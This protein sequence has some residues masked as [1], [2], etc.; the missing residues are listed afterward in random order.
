MWGVDSG[1]LYEIDKTSGTA[2]NPRTLD[3][4]SDYQAVALAVPPFFPP[5]VEGTVFEDASGNAVPAGEFVGDF[6]NPGFAGATVRMYNDDGS[7]PGEPDA[8]DSLYASKATGPTGHYY[9]SSVPAGV[10]WLTVDSAALTPSAGGSGWPEQTYAPAEA[11]TFNGSYSYSATAGP[12]YGGMRPTVADDA[13]LLPSSEHVVRVD[14][15]PG[16]EIEQVDVGLSF[17]VVTNLEGGDGT[18][19]QGSLAQFIDNANTVT[20]PNAMRFV[21]AVPTNDI[22]GSDSWWRLDVTAALPQI[23][24]ADT[25][26]DG[27]AFDSADGTTVLDTNTAQIGGGQT[28]GVDAATSTARLDPELAIRNDRSTP[29]GNGLDVQGDGTVLTDFAIYGFGIGGLDADLR[30]GDNGGGPIVDAVT[31]DRV[32]V[33]TDPSRNTNPGPDVT[34][35]VGVLVAKSTNGVFRDS[36]VRSIGNYGMRLGL[37][38]TDWQILGS[39]FSGND[40]GFLLTSSGASVAGTLFASNTN[41]G[42][43]IS[44]DGQGTIDNN[45][46]EFNAGYGLALFSTA[47]GNTV[48]ENIISNNG[49]GIAVLNPANQNRLSQNTFGGNDTNGI[50]LGAGA[51]D[52]ITLNSGVPP[53]CGYSAG[54][55][56]NDGID[57]PVILS[58]VFDAGSTTINGTGCA[59]AEVEIYRAVADGD[60]SDT[61]G[62]TDFGEGVEYLGTVMADGV[63]GSFALVTGLLVQGDY[64]S[65]TSTDA[66]GNTS[67]FGANTEVVPSNTAPILDAVGAQSGDEGTLITFTATGSDSDL[68][69]DTLTFTLEDGAGSV[70]AGAS[71]TG[72]GVFTFTPSE[73]QGPGVFS[74]DVVVTDDGTPNLTDR[75]TITVTVNEVNIAPVL[76]AVGAQSGDEGTLV[77]FTATAS[78][79]DVPAN[80]LTFTL[81]DGAGS[82]PVGAVITG[83]GVFTFTPSEAQGPGVFSFDVVVTDDGTPN[84]T[85]RETITVTVSEVNVAPVLD[86]VGAQ[87]GDEGTLISFL[88]TAS[89]VDLPADTLT[90]TLEDGAG[91]VPAGAVITGGGAFTFTPSEAQGPGVYSFDVVVTDDGTPT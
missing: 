79:V 44:S 80:T 23:T 14:L 21:P 68:P 62:A 64:V 72:G 52:G 46:F 83:G 81:E 70:P 26:I 91:S 66:A 29:V 19:P 65:A 33:G 63:T 27:T 36:L 50:D 45:T 37:T 59:G 8:T 86:A 56:G 3:N 40:T 77:T 31:V 22:N 42:L 2:A 16:E 5:S 53:A 15:S 6:L 61:A 10:Y 43:T 49:G 25:T 11:V 90:F 71:I 55:V 85:D 58:A 39:E 24:D 74:F 87:S 13:T 67:E 32:V 75:E 17:N 41:D 20:G 34:P 69:A 57:S 48:S 38:S 89:D 28:V 9:F 78:D 82:V 84:L 88:A 18:S 76:D 51:T 73:A 60:A 30:I 7:V 47:V 4:G 1:A 35:F 54:L 12:L